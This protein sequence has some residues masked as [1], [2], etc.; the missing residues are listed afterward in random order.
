MRRSSSAAG[1]AGLSATAWRVFES[2]HAARRASTIGGQCGF[3]ATVLRTRASGVAAETLP[4]S[5]RVPRAAAA[6]HVWPT[7]RSQ[8][9]RS[10]VSERSG[11]SGG[12][13]T[14]RIR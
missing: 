9:P 6:A 12:A 10:P 4:G 5:P 14:P 11:L 7:L 3:D 13:P 8:R 2:R 1:T